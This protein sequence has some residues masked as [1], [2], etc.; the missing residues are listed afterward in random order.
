MIDRIPYVTSFIKKLNLVFL[1]ILVCSLYYIPT[2]LPAETERNIPSQSKTKVLE[3][4]W[5]DRIIPS[6]ADDLFVIL[7][8]GMTI[9]IRESH[10]S[11]VVSCQVLVKTGSIYEGSKMGGGLSH[12]LEHV[13]SGGTNSRFTESEIKERVQAI[14]GAANAYTSYERTVYFINTTEEHYKE[15]IS[16]LLAYVTDCQ[17]NDKE[18]KRE[19]PVIIQEFQMGENN[20]SRQLW[21]V[22][23]KT[24]YRKHPVRYPIIGEKDI[25]LKINR[26]DLIS[27]YHRWYM[28]ENMVISVAGDV[29]REEVLN[30][31]IDLAGRLKR[32]ENFPYVLPQEPPQ[33]SYRRVEKGLPIAKLAQAQ[34]GFRTITLTNPDLYPLDVLAIIMGDG[35]TSRLYKKVKDQKGLVL[36]IDAGS[37]TPTFVQG[38]FLISMDL[39]YENLSSAI[40]AIWEELS[41]VRENFVSEEAL[42]RAKNKVVAGYIFSQ[43]SLRSQARQI[44]MDWVSTGDPYFNETYVSR[45]KQVTV[46]D[47]KRVAQK[48]FKK[49]KMTLAVIKPL[50][51]GSKIKKALAPFSVVQ[52]EIEKIILPNHMILLLKKNPSTPIVSFKF[53]LK[54]GLR[55]EPPD[56]P[57]LSYFMAS[58]LTKGTKNRSKIEITKTIEDLGGSIGS[59]SGYNT[60]SISVSTLKENFDTALDLLADV[61]L[62]PTFP[63]NEIEKQRE[64]TLLKIRRL[65]E[66]WTREIT[67]LFKKHYYH[68]HPYRND[69]IGTLQ[70]VKGFSDK[71]MRYFYES[72]MLPN[73]SVLA[74]FGDIKPD[75]VVLKVEKIFKDFKPG[76]FKEPLID[77][78]TQNISKDETFEVSNKKS[79]AAILVGY[80]GLTLTDKELPVVDILDAIISGIGYPSGWL[81]DSLRGGEKSLVYYV[82]AYPAFGIDGGYFGVIAQ[83]TTENY[84]E[85]VKIILD[86]M[87]FIRSEEVDEETLSRAKNI[88]ITMHELGLETIAAQASSAALNE[89]LGLGSSYDA[90]YP[91]LIQKVT[92]ADVLRVARRLFSQHLIVATKPVLKN[93]R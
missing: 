35:R 43:E 16:L 73:N 5:I 17:F 53:F 30:T 63:E 22:F 47:V 54:G 90:D 32:I 50:K 85:V 65:D 14:G 26:D 60:V 72:I 45:I 79:S 71:D 44:A 42:K 74:I 68:K 34:M 11:K 88:C 9:L 40:D 70:A 6:K 13:V 33:L 15:A 19:K 1:A 4:Q 66:Q 25:F 67:R 56:K 37:W 31:V 49:E 57:G 41:D 78:E 39:P 75:S 62:N 29:N 59:S 64:E 20:P 38:Q 24:A 91:A 83:T 82:H 58:L 89:I 10:A 23:M 55:F 46:E 21:S 77:V 81:H 92:A 80:N 76:T 87:A 84:D 52:G 2:A 12:Y 36:S 7:K 28:P 27:Y 8:N 69:V 61:V 86:K 18:F 3:S 48:Y 51:E 93:K